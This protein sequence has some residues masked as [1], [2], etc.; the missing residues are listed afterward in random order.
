MTLPTIR[1]AGARPYPPRVSEFTAPF[2]EALAKGRL[3]TT[4]GKTS[5][6]LSFP[7]KPFCPF[8]WEREVEWAELSG[9]GILYSHTVVHAAPSVF[10]HLAPYRVCIV[11]LEE[12]LGVAG[13]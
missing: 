3:V 8:S 1:R 11:D 13:A 12:G 4:R 5:G 2:W 7:P 9:R 6:R 10:A